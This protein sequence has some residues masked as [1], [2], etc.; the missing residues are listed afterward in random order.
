LCFLLSTAP[1]MDGVATC[2]KCGGEM[3]EG[4]FLDP[5]N[6][7]T[8]RWF[9]GPPK[10]AIFGGMQTKGNESYSVKSF[11]CSK[12]GFLELYAPAS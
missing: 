5:D 1:T 9:A 11:R 12:C 3:T 2:P 4:F 7:A 8:A 10:K 6:W